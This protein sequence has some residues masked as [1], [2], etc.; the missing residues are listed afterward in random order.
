MVSSKYHGGIILNIIKQL[1][2]AEKALEKQAHRIA[3]EL[4]QLR[5]AIAALGHRGKPAK[6]IAKKRGMSAAAR[7]KIAAAQKKRWAAVRAGK[8]NG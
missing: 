4:S 7:K 8:K 2:K 6:K 5:N 3:V 1:K